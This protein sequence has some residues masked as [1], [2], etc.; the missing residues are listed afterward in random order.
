MKRRIIISLLALF[1]FF[2]LGTAIATL[3]IRNTTIALS[4]LIQL[5]Q[6]EGLRQDLI[7][8]IQNVQSDL[9]T[10]HTSLGRTTDS[11]ADH[12]AGM[13]KAV[14]KC[15]G[16]HHEPALAKQL[17]D[18]GAL[19]Y[20]YRKALSYFITAAAD[21]KLMTK[22]QA[23]AA[24]VGNDILLRTGDMSLLASRKLEGMTRETKA[25][26]D[27]AWAIL[28]ATIGSTFIMAVMVAAR[29][30]TSVTRPIYKL[31]NATRMI[32]SGS[33]GYTIQLEDKTEFGEL[34]SHFNSMSAALKESY[35]SLEK[36]I[37]ERIQTGEAL[38]KS[39]AF[40]N[41]IFD[42]IGD[43]FCIID[44]EYRIVRANEAYAALKN[45][46]LAD[47][48]G[49]TC[50]RTLENREDLCEGCI[51]RKTF[52][53]GDSCAKEKFSAGPDG[54]K[55]W[56]EI[57]TYPIS[58]SE[59]RITHVIEYT[60]DVTD[61]KRAQ[62]ALLVSEERYALAAR[63]ANDGLWDWDLTTNKVYYSYRWKSMLGYGEQ[64]V[65]DHPDEWLRKV[66]PDDREELETKMAAHISAR[67]SHFEGEYRIFH[68]DGT[69]RWM[70]SRGLAVRNKEGHA[71]RMA[72]SQTDITARKTAEEQLLY[73][74]FHDALTG[75]PNRALFMDR[76]N[77]VIL[78]S[79]RIKGYLYAV[80]FLDIDR[81]KVVNDSMGH[82]IGDQLLVSVSGKLSNCVRP[83]DTIARLGGDEFAVLLENI[84]SVVDA[85]DI[86]KR[87]RKTLSLPFMIGGH[88]L[89]TS[90]SIGIALGDSSHTLPEH[91]LRDA[92]I[93]MY[94]AKARGNACHEVFDT[95]MY[96]S[97]VDRLQL[98]AD[99]H[100]AVEHKEFVMHYQPIVDVKAHRLTGFEA[101]VRW[102]HPDKGLIY[103]LEFI[104]L[105]EETGLIFALSEWIF[106]ES[107]SQLRVW[108]EQYRMSPPLKMSIN[109]SGKQFS[110]PDF[111]ASFSSVIRE[112]GLEPDSIALEITE[113]MIM[114][115]KESASEIMSRLR[116][117]GVHIHIDDFGTGYSSLSYL[118]SFPVSALKID[119]T[120][121]GNLTEK[122]DNGEIIN[123]IVSLA[124]SLNLDVIAEG[125]EMSHQLMNIKGMNCGYAQGLLFA[126]PMDPRELAAWMQ[127]GG[128][129]A[130]EPG[131]DA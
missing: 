34:A 66:H 88:E 68:R 5:H 28:L 119:K 30:T 107:C 70:L 21:E 98:E 38:R 17:A 73:D 102:N 27:K 11:I 1:F 117:M 81:F 52:L 60:R 94:Q 4:R 69:Y 16:C 14:R 114:E 49:R 22:L 74:A 84:S 78:I 124:Q 71:Y 76:L 100:R 103:P 118:L 105:A 43:P 13:E 44:G 31:V 42:S 25:N 7:I 6:V 109:I 123:S 61:R 19:I 62:E 104:G 48:P 45:K 127:A 129:T 85:V 112:T 79:Q 39:E 115:N 93:A 12:V 35:S 80:L 97:I 63:G 95:G 50:Y 90:A 89:F 8:S 37:G 23:D 120:F 110:R 67:S 9:Y 24:A 29:L 75:L 92:D 18:V 121:I 57:F 77:H 108:Q 82:T 40:L 2:T 91:I 59:G 58:D 10:V 51:V 122:G 26:I 113:S 65:A 64:E 32:A 83:V 53:S 3:Y 116:K 96:A 56:L 128:L 54:M 72:G 36:E 87:I 55:I 15:S 46:G 20:D 101:L 130:E 99:L 47:L 106:Q 41:T 131:P 111:I 86:A 33:L 125:V 126:G